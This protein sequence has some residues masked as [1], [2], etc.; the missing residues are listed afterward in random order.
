[1]KRKWTVEYEAE[2]QQRL[3]SGSGKTAKTLAT[4]L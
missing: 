1:M 3:A 2:Q 4:A